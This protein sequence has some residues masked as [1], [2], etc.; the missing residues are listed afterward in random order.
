[1]FLANGVHAYSAAIFHLVTH[2]FFKALL[3]LGAGAVMHALDGELDMRNMGGLRSKMPVTALTFLAGTLAIS[4]IVPFAGFW[5]KDA[6]LASA[7]SQGQYAMWTIGLGTAGRTAFY[8]FRLYFRV[9]EGKSRVAE[10][11]H[12]HDAPPL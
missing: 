12:V 6:L 3:F 9:F 8:M 4:G 2:A 7:W 11:I 5:S 10:G 1:M